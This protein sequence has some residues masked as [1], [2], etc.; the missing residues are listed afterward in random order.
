MEDKL[1][2]AFKKMIKILK[3]HRSLIDS[4]ISKFGIHGTHHRILMRLSVKGNLLSQKELSEH[5]EITPAAVTQALQKLETDGFIERKLGADNRYNEIK[6][7]DRGM[8]IVEKTKTV[9]TSI[10]KAFFSNFTVVEIDEFLAMLDRIIE[11]TKG[12]A[13]NEKMV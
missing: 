3:L 2:L 7:T 5:L 4:E 9:F 8:E 10:D 6:I 1:F 13:E 11:N 12:E